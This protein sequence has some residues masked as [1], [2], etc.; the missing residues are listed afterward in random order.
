MKNNFIIESESSKLSSIGAGDLNLNTIIKQRT[1]I[2]LLT[3]LK[4]Y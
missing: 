3:S 4:R 2:M 1:N